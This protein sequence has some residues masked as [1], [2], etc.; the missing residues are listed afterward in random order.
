MF[1]MRA[2]MISVG[3]LGAA[4][5]VPVDF[6]KADQL[7]HASWY[8]LPANKTANGERMNPDE[9]TAAHRSLPFG[10]RVV[11]ENL[12][13][14]RSVVVRI[15]DRGPFIG[16]RII[17]LSKAAAASIGMIATGTAKVRVTTAAGGV[18]AGLGESTVKAKGESRIHEAASPAAPEAAVQ[19]VSA[20]M[21]GATAT[22]AKA[23][24]KPS[25]QAN[26]ASKP[27]KTKTLAVTAS[28]AS[29]KRV[30]SQTIKVAAAKR[31]RPSANAKAR[32]QVVAAANG[33]GTGREAS[34]ASSRRVVVASNGIRAAAREAS[35]FS[36]RPMIVA[37]NGIRTAAREAS[38][39]SSRRVN[40]A[41][42]TLNPYAVSGT[43]PGFTK[44]ARVRAR[45]A[46]G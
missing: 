6:A 34:R 41:S 30:G 2:K 17:D 37:S 18:L 11:V 19:I 3:L 45:R 24:P 33:L 10:T 32:V 1:K 21:T 13:N 42:N 20:K 39:F 31:S 4:A 23:S 27:A 29:K 16:G 7:G 25:Q 36:S 44:S 14:G 38:R 35:R 8:S 22:E 28:A 12:S 5:L 26:V 46:M 43:T 15:N 40:V 9:L